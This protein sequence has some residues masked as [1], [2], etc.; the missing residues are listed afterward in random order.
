MNKAAKTTKQRYERS[1][2]RAEFIAMLYLRLK[3]YRILE[4][5]FKTKLGEIDIIAQKSDILVAVEVKRRP[6]LALA[7]DSLSWE[8]QNRI[9]HA[10]DVYVAKSSSARECGIRFDAIFITGRSLRTWRLHH[11]IDG[12]RG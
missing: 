12:W 1:G 4:R 7:H 3:G 6:T 10:I 9:S 5:R 11:I 8:S 2:R